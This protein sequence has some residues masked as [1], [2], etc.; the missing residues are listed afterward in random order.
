MEIVGN[1]AKRMIAKAGLPIDV[2]LTLDRKEA[3]KN[4]DFVTTQF[5]VGLLKA[6]AKDERIPLKYG[7]L[8]QETNGPGG[9]FKGL[10]TNYVR[11]RGLLILPI[12]QE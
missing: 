6:R 1:L 3:L 5:R 10:Q 11:M 4:A 7:V 9:L 2:Y 12:Q 8:G